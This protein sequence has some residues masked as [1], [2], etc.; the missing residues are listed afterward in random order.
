MLSIL[1]ALSDISLVMDCSGVI[2]DVKLGPSDHP[3]DESKAWLGL[4]WIDVVTLES[5]GKVGDMLAE[6]A[7]H[8]LSGR[9]QVNH[10]CPG[11][12]D[13]PVIYTVVRLDG[14]RDE[15]VAIGRDVRSLVA[16][17]RQL[18]D[19]QQSLERDY[20]RLRQVESQYRLLFQVS[21]EA[22]LTLD[23]R[24][25][26]VSEANPA[27]ERLFDQPVKRLIGRT[28]PFGMEASSEA[29]VAEQLATVRFHGHGENIRVRLAGSGRTVT[30]AMSL[31][32]QDA[33]TLVLA[34]MFPADE[35]VSHAFPALAGVA[36]GL[37]EASP[38]G[39]VLADAEGRV[40]M[41]NDAF[42]DMVDV[43]TREQVRGRL[44][45]DWV[46]RPG[47]DIERLLLTV[48]DHGS[49]RLFATSI[50]GE[51]GSSSE[52]E[53]SGVALAGPAGPQVGLV[54]R[55]VGR[56]LVPRP[57]GASDLSQAVEQLASL[58]GRVALKDLVRDTTDL[59]QRHFIE[60][61]LLATEDNRTSAAEMLGMSRQSLYMKL[62][63]Y[64]K[65]AEP[66]LTEGELPG[67]NGGTPG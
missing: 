3:L 42:M 60:A 14:A 17:E 15:V 55:D 47:A 64:G 36:L 37:L 54:I 40:A 38:D 18:I 43:S 50:R 59:V 49:V 10:T 22:V 48:H 58:L 46:G 24:T 31:L 19:A 13:I 45:S 44:L 9:Y 62:R 26:K 20:W 65:G 21:V 56:R 27:A 33:T 53:I 51:L 34:R 39:V 57:R 63:R 2:K 6:V 8:G 1:A 29:I 66:S 61:A 11:G 16:I 35:P 4:S 41:A 67:G 12:A 30:L 7:A 5:R 25:L 32:R 52:V 23:A 28:F